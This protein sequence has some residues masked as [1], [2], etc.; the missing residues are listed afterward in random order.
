MAIRLSK[1]RRVRD[2]EVISYLGFGGQGDAYLAQAPDGSQVV[3]KQLK[4]S[5]SAPDHADNAE[6]VSR[7]RLLIGK[8]HAKVCSALDVF[9]DRDLYYVVTAYV[10]DAES[11]DKLLARDGPLEL[12]PALDIAGQTLEGLAWLHDQGIVHRDIKPGNIM[13]GKKSR[14]RLQVT[15]I[16]IDL[17]L[18]LPLPRLTFDPRGAG[19]LFGPCTPQYA[20]VEV[21]RAGDID[22][23]ADLYSVGATLFE[24]LTGSLPW[25][26]EAGDELFRLVCDPARPSVRD[27]APAVPATVDAYVQRLM[28]LRPEDRPDHARQA[29][30]ELAVLQESLGS[31]PRPARSRAS[32]RPARHPSPSPVPAA[33]PPPVAPP[34]PMPR[35]ILALRIDSGDLAGALVAI[36]R[37]GIA[38]GR[39]DINP[40]DEFIS[41][42]HCRVYPVRDLLKV[43]DLC[44]RNGLLSLGRR[45]RRGL[46]RPGESAQIGKTLVTCVIT[47]GGP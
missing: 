5:A 27:R 29:M 13:I 35:Q 12:P 9:V 10:A 11:L 23:R 39:G 20:P 45:R 6:R 38:L 40:S 15:V 34:P 19:D 7:L 25:P 42:T 30:D 18:H 41:R 28:A 2:Y 31:L 37:R 3:L 46:L 21:I 16:D 1:G 22:P 4:F 17:A 33:P 24:M 8:R 47:H 26:L 36:P 32:H 14:A 43:R 44:S